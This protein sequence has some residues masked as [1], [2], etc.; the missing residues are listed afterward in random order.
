MLDFRRA[1]A[2]VKFIGTLAYYDR[3]DAL[4]VK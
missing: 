4:P 3:I 1:I 2:F